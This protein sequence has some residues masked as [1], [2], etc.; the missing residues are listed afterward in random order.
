MKTLLIILLVL[1]STSL[2]AQ[3]ITDIDIDDNGLIEIND[4]E[5]LN[6]IRYQLDGS[7]LQLSETAAEI[8]T[9]CAP[10][11]CKGYELARDLDFNDDNS[12]SSTANKVIWTTGEGWQPIGNSFWAVFDGN[13]YTISNLMIDSSSADVGLFDTLGSSAEIT[14]LGL[15]NVN[16]TG[17]SNVG[18]LAGWN[19]GTITNSYAMCSVSGTSTVGGLVGRNYQGTIVNSYAMCSVSGKSRST[20]RTSRIGGLVGVNEGTITDSYAMG[21]VIGASTVGGLVGRNNRNSTITNSY[22]TVSTTGTSNVGGLVGS[23]NG[24]ITDSYAMGSVI[25]NFYCRRFG[26]PQ[27]SRHNRTNSYTMSSVSG[28]SRS[29]T[30]HSYVGGLVGDNEGTITD[31]YA[32]G[33]VI[34]TSSVGGLVG[35][36]NRNS[37][38][39][40]SYAIVSTTGTSY[41]RWSCW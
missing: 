19:F 29:T 8:T 36:N 20:A 18:S 13:G 39:T 10:G 9:G 2:I 12:Y 3:T 5:A 14:N 32:M 1:L 37:T 27:L 40:N 26:W 33:S 38:I 17:T 30:R 15:L 28:K 23:N 11:G 25:G 16:T 41:C 4:L 34:G 31:S 22:A 6:A 21:S 35:R 7:G 24:A